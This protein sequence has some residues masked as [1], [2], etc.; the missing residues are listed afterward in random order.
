MTGAA[1]TRS[2]RLVAQA[3]ACLALCLAAAC[4]DDAGDAGPSSTATDPSAPVTIEIRQQ[5]GSIEP[6]D[7]RVVEVEQGQPIQ[8]VVTSDVADEIHVHSD[9]EHE[10]EIR[11]GADAEELPSFT[12]ESP[13]RF[14]VESH[15]LELT[16]VT[17]Q[18]S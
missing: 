14:P 12:L 5:D 3:A 11:K 9:P 10:F 8:L 17:L 13:G 16:L 18:V 7:G 2:T 6:A 4:G 15:H 1:L